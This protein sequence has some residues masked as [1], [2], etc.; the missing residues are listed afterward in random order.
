MDRS[1]LAE[2]PCNPED[3]PQDKMSY[4]L[5]GIRTQRRVVWALML[6]ETKTLFGKHKLGYLWAF[7]NA[8]FS[9]GIFWGL[10]ELAGA[11]APHGLT[12]PVFL[13]GGF[14]PWYLFAETLSGAM[15]GVSGNRALLAYPQVFPIDI[16]LARTL[17]HGSMYTCVLAF[18]LF[19]AHF[20]GYPVALHDPGAVLMALALALMLGFG[21]GAVCSAFNLL[22]PT[23]R[24]LVPMVMRVLFFTTGLF[25]SVELAPGYVRDI[26]QYNPMSHLLELARNGLSAGYESH[27]VDLDYVYGFILVA[28]AAGLL[29]ERY[30]RRFMNEDL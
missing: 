3:A 8:A 7:I 30:S 12:T 2:S 6:R 27:F 14:I 24:L 18:F 9:I 16:L 21:L 4:L 17:L 15:S 22:W 28:I 23:T 5:N 11:T 13:L 26:L 1:P 20:F 25:F 10:R 29:L 19:V